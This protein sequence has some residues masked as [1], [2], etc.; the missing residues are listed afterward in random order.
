MGRIALIIKSA[1]CVLVFEDI[2][3]KNRPK[4]I[5][6]D[7]SKYL[8]DGAYCFNCGSKNIATIRDQLKGDCVEKDIRCADCGAEWREIWSAAPGQDIELDL[9]ELQI[10]CTMIS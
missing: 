7:M 6:W 4:K 2:I 3:T 10:D 1:M 5:S 9:E 8:D